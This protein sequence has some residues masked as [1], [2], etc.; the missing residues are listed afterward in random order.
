MS[1]ITKKPWLDPSKA[2]PGK[3]VGQNYCHRYRRGLPGEPADLL[4]SLPGYLR[5]GRVDLLISEVAVAL[6]DKRTY[7]TWEQGFLQLFQYIQKTKPSS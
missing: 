2:L 1:Q 3:A 5:P 6:G 7:D 4:L